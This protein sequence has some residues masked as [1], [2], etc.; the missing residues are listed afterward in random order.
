MEGVGEVQRTKANDRI[1]DAILT[2]DLH[3]TDTP[4]VS[5]TDNYQEAQENKLQFL[6]KLSNQNDY[7]P[8]LCAGDTFHQWKASPWLMQWVF[9]NL[10]RPFITIPGNHDLPGHSLLEYD[11]SALHLIEAVSDDI[12]VLIEGIV[13]TDNLFIVG[14]PFGT[15]DTFDPEEIQYPEGKR[16]ILMLHE[17]TWQDT[18]PFW[19][20]GAADYTAQGLLAKYGAYFDLI[21][22]GDNHSGF[23]SAQDD[24]ILVNPGS[25]LRISADKA[26]YVPRCY[27]YYA[28]TN[29]VTAVDYP[30]EKNVHNREHID[31]KRERD[32]RIAAY[33]ERMGTDWEIGLS[34]SKNLEAFFVE[35]AVPKKVRDI[36][37]QSL[38]KGQK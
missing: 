10:P 23:V 30:I 15:L 17:L 35:N 14:R 22:T 24:A 9:Y 29:T 26:E 34:F 20:K 3:L 25:M 12:T 32:E 16:R 11:R 1:A 4:P 2:S 36:I 37:Y 6:Q 7:C 31:I 5:R 13:E 8:I 33:I 27:L 28:D 19:R 18:N 38:E 21:L